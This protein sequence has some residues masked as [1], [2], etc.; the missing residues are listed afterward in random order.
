MPAPNHMW[1]TLEGASGPGAGSVNVVQSGPGHALEIEKIGDVS[2]RIG[3]QFS[4]QF[5]FMASWGVELATSAGEF[6]NGAFTDSGYDHVTGGLPNGTSTFS[7]HHGSEFVMG[8]VGQVLQFDL[9]AP[10]L[11]INDQTNV[12]GDFFVGSFSINGFAWYGFV[13]PNPLS[14]GLPAYS[15]AGSPDVTPGWGDL[16]V[17]VVREVPEPAVIGLLG[18]SSLLVIR[19]RQIAKR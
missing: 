8:S 10:V 12:T 9:H 11:A 5:P 14:Y 4:S 13:G 18:F 17:I 15:M 7:I 19:R 1:F 16:P 2:L 6:S 3:L